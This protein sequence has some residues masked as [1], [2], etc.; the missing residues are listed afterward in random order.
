MLK[1]TAPKPIL[2]VPTRWGSTYDMIERLLVLKPIIFDFGKL[3]EA[4]KLEE[5]W[6]AMENLDTHMK[7]P[8]NASIRIQDRSL[9]FG[10]LLAE[11]ELMEFL[12]HATWAPISCSVW[13]FR[14]RKHSVVGNAAFL[15]AVMWTFDIIA[16]YLLNRKNVQKNIF[17]PYGEFF[18]SK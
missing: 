15:G 6:F 14:A 18:F 7:A 1:L 2:D 13:A 4:I 17:T 16:Y 8:R 9:T 5:E 10:A 12:A 3:N 11:W